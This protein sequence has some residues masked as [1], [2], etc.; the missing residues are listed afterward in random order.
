MSIAW[1]DDPKDPK[2]WELWYIPY[3]GSCRILSINR[4]SNT[5]AAT[6]SSTTDSIK[7]HG[8][9]DF[10]LPHALRIIHSNVHLYDVNPQRHHN[11]YQ[12]MDIIIIITIVMLSPPSASSLHRLL[13]SSVFWLT[14]DPSP[15][16][17]SVRIW[18]CSGVRA[19][20]DM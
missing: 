9:E 20:S 10:R 11:H 7:R 13:I 17:A 15:R 2:L 19:P 14:E 1:P 16:L 3:Y 18:R 12:I 5:V 4:S 8:W 6:G